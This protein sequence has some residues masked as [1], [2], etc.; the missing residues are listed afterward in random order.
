[1]QIK[2]SDDSSTFDELRKSIHE[3][4]ANLYYNKEEQDDI[5]LESAQFY[6]KRQTIPAEIINIGK[7]LYLRA[8]TEYVFDDA[9]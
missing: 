9:L 5:D 1:V 3:E 6:I 8:N 2:G 4:I 7:P